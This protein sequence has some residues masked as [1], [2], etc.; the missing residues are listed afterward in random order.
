VSRTVLVY[1][2]SNANSGATTFPLAKRYPPINP[3]VK[4]TNDDDDPLSSHA[5]L[6]ATELIYQRNRQ[7]TRAV[8]S[9]KVVDEA[10]AL[11]ETAVRLWRQRERDTEDSQS[12][13][14]DDDAAS[15]AG[16]RVMPN[17]GQVTIFSGINS[18]GYPNPNSFH[19]GEVL[20]K[21]DGVKAL[22]TFFYEVP[23]HSFSTRE[24]FGKRVVERE[25]Q[26]LER[27]FGSW[28]RRTS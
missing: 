12:N 8:E 13:N 3:T 24:E 16:I 21:G 17:A 4:D 6:A 22:L 27:H 18:D 10:V 25:Q 1:L 2:T 7:H 23:L 11:E 14:N 28:F 15:T 5:K 9:G 19:G 20:Q 26:F